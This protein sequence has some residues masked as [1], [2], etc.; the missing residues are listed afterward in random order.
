MFI[1]GRF[2]TV[3]YLA[4]LGWRWVSPECSIYSMFI[5]CIIYLEEPVALSQPF[6]TISFV[7]FYCR[8]RVAEIEWFQDVSLPEGSQERRDV[9][10]NYLIKF[11]SFCYQ[12]CLKKFQ[13]WWNMSFYLLKPKEVKGKQLYEN[14]HFFASTS[15]SL[16][17]YALTQEMITALS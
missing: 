4:I 12:K 6:S 15:E 1:G 11:I 13:L 10:T 9:K 17:T 8:Y 7:F 2:T 16:Y 3:S 5:W 14:R